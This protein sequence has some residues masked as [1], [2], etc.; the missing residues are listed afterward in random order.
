MRLAFLGSLPSTRDL[1]ASNEGSPESRERGR[2]AGTGAQFGVMFSPP[3]KKSFYC[4][5]S[6]GDRVLI[7]AVRLIFRGF[8]RIAFNVA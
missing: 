2:N 3:M 6:F 1:G 4:R 8:C 5:S 7:F